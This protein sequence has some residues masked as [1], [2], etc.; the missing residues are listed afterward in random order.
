MIELLRALAYLSE[1]P[2]PAHAKPANALGLG[3]LPDAA[4]YTDCF[5][6]QFHP[7]ASIYLGPEG[8][9]G[10]VAR[11]RIAG[12]WRALSLDPPTEPDHLT[13][14]LALYAS[15]VEQETSSAEPATRQAWR[16]AR[17]AYLWE[18]LLTWLPPY[19]FR[20]QEIGPEFYRRWAA[21]TR[22]VLLAEGE[23]VGTPE[24]QSLHFR[25]APALPSVEALDL[26]DIVSWVLAPIHS[27]MI[28]L[29]S[30]LLAGGYSLGLGL[31]NGERRFVLKEL[32]KDN[33]VGVLGWLA[34]TA[35]AWS[36]RHC[37]SSAPLIG[38][39]WAN[40]AQA[41]AVALHTLQQ[42]A[43]KHHHAAA[44]VSFIS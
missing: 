14:M 28:L 25:E 5:L 33:A 1:P 13:I 31:R 23:T 11:D 30:D 21:L 15:L 27:G 40:R 19:L 12:F 8:M 7:Y 36:T 22:E 42:L 4:E 41:T 44:A 6:L 32:L 16:N 35:Q 34:A 18:H 38:D 39:W 20:M 29:R 17:K 2:T 37:Q 3:P 9:M 10:G 43:E 26:D 24:R